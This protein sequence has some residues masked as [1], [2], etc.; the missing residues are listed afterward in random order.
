MIT[1]INRGR[2]I[3]LFCF[4]LKRR[5][6]TEGILNACVVPVFALGWY[7]KCPGITSVTNKYSIHSS[8]ITASSVLVH[9]WR[10]SAV[11]RQP[12]RP[13]SC[14]NEAGDRTQEARPERNVK[15]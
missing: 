10:S 4:L 9:H 14:P 6:L 8:F 11:P 5:G 7:H 3:F 2:G 1:L 12:G 13:S 15:E